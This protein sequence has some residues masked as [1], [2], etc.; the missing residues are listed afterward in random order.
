MDVGVSVIV[1]NA[2]LTMMLSCNVH[3]YGF[4]LVHNNRKASMFVISEHVIYC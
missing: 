2:F 1:K 4:L 3:V